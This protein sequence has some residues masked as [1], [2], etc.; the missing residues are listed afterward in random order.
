M[1]VKPGDEV[2]GTGITYGNSG[3]YFSA[4]WHPGNDEAEALVGKFAAP[5][6][7]GALPAWS[8]G[9]PG[10]GGFDAFL[11]ADVGADG[12]YFPGAS[13]SQ[14]SDSV[15]GKERKEIVAK[16]NLDGTSGSDT[17]G[18]VWV[19]RQRFYPGSNGYDGDEFFNAAR[20]SVEGGTTYFYGG[21]HAQE[22]GCNNNYAIRKYTATGATVWQWQQLSGA[23]G[24]SDINAIAVDGTNVYAAGSSSY[25][26]NVPQV[27][28]FSAAAGSSGPSATFTGT[29]DAGYTSAAYTSVA[30]LGGNIYAAGYLSNGERQAYLLDEWNT[31]GTRLVHQVWSSD[32]TKANSQQLTGITA[33]GSRL[34]V[35]GWTR[36]LDNPATA[37]NMGGP[38]TPVFLDNSAYHGFGDGV[39]FE[40]N[41]SNGDVVST[42]T[43]GTNDAK[44]QAF[45]GVTTDGTD[46]YV[47]GGERDATGFY[48]VIVQR[49][50]LSVPTTLTTSAAGSYGGTAT[51]QAAL[52]GSGGPISGATVNF[53]LSGNAVGS[54]VTGANGV[55]S[56]TNVSLAGVDAGS[57]SGVVGAAFAA[58]GNFQGSNATGDLTVSK[59]GATITVT[60]AGTFLYNGQT[61]AAA[62]SVTGVLVP[63][64]TLGSATITYTD[65]STNS[66]TS[67]APVNA[68]SYGVNASFAGNTNYLPGANN[69]LTI[70]ITP[71][72]TTTSAT[73][74]ANPS[75]FGQSVT[76]TATVSAVAPGAGTPTGTVTFKDA[77]TTLGTGTLIGGTTTFTTS[78]LSVASHTVTAV[79]GGDTNFTTST[80]PTVT[81]T[82]SQAST[83]TSVAS[84]ATPSVFGQPVTF[85]ATVAAVS[86]S[87]GTPSGT[88][89]FKD[90]ATTLG[91][92]TLSGGTA[93]FT[94]S[95]LSVASHVITASYSGDVSFSASAAQPVWQQLSPT[96]TGPDVNSQQFVS[97]GQGSLIMFGGCGPTG[98]N[99]SSNTFALRD[100]FGVNGTTAW[101][102]IPTTTNPGARHAHVLAYDS[103]LNELIASGGCAGGCYPLAPDTWKLTNGNGLG[104][105]TPTWSQVIPSAPPANG[106]LVGQFAAVDSAHSA[107][108]IYG[109]QN[110]GGSACSGSTTG[111]TETVNTSTFSWASLPTS[112]GPP[113]TQ[114][115]SKGGYDPNSN[116]LIISNG[117]GCAN[118]NELWILTHANGRDTGSTPT[119]TKL[120]SQGAAGS[121]PGGVWPTDYSPARNT[122]FLVEAS[123]TLVPNLWRLSNAN[124]LDASGTATTPAWTLATT[125]GGPSGQPSI[126]GIAYDSASD[127]LVAQLTVG[128][129]IQYWIIKSASGSGAS[130][131]QAVTPASTT[132]TVVSSANPSVS[133]QSVT[134]TATVSVTSPGAGTPTGAVTFKDGANTLGSGTV[135][136]SGQATFATSALSVAGHSITA[137]Y[138]GDTNFATSTS[139]ALSHTVNP[140]PPPTSVFTANSNPAACS[141][142]LTFDGSGSY[143]SSGLHVVSYAWNF[144]DGVTGTGSTTTHAYSTFGTY[145]ATLTVT[146]NNVPAKTGASTVVVNVNQGNHAPVANHGGPYSTD[147]GA[148][149]TLNGTGSS[150]ADTLCG[151][152]ITSYAW[153]IGAITFIAAS[154]SLTAAQVNALG[155][156]T[157]PVSL[158]VTD[159]FGV[160]N[161]A[162]TTLSI[163]NNVPT[164]SFTANPNPA[165]CQQTLTFNGSSSTAGRPDRAIVGYGWN[166]GDGVTASGSTT[167]HA[168]STFGSYNATLTVT[169]NNVPAK[170]GASTLV[171]NVNQGNSA[172]VANAG[173]PYTAS[174]GSAFALN[175]SG[176]S[177]PNASCGD[178][179]SYSWTIDGG[180]ITSTAQSPSLTVA[181]ISSLGVGNHNVSLTVTDIFGVNGNASTSLTIAD[182]LA[183]VSVTPSLPTIPQG[184]SQTFTAT[185]SYGSGAT[186]V[187]ANDSWTSGTPLTVASYGPGA[188]V[189]NG[190][191]YV[192]SG[193]V[194]QR[195]A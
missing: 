175:G 173:G 72:S 76:F 58:T 21:G 98:C 191:L 94:T 130:T 95:S 165:A 29:L 156:G 20:V 87:A 51:L 69:S 146:D 7:N 135:N 15:G 73:S 160:T 158:T 74:S 39:I 178:V 16:F 46:L 9:W 147:L 84:S 42:T 119:W 49:Y 154:P 166:F 83:T 142:S 64:D 176:S 184:G 8:R 187:L 186:R 117:W 192:I 114:Y 67:S 82:V 6:S 108:M 28:R 159:T 52:S 40:I 89:T 125:T 59:T 163:Y 183:S 93:T 150:D 44:D 127:R 168:Y 17:A 126:G 38:T 41:P 136:G 111:T 12:V 1:V 78:S 193:F 33:V 148:G 34:F 105:G 195:V 5:M 47:V 133:G 174:L 138:G 23:C 129:S 50:G 103:I 91:T 162:S 118:Y 13:Y 35:T 96:G 139:S 120:L 61:H 68:G 152:S 85:T 22:N 60:G 144:G 57:Y 177:D 97:D 131:S 171:V 56:L 37:H 62:G 80:S 188:A 115:L 18:A 24:G 182:S 32:A 65:L 90:G 116:R 137:V 100:A 26:G 81:Q 107:L 189:V 194:T 19:A 179:I 88:V 132:T 3:V 71:A 27:L 4:F 140:A 157:F 99:T 102:Q 54:T 2:V 169:D 31:S 92:G 77:S 185:A 66:T 112:G 113:G 149:V 63:T 109:G 172:P 143:A 134:F 104:V 181:Q 14:T 190:Q 121:P 75:V 86:P 55:A 106:Y 10:G 36:D 25:A 180:A 153:T 124:G 43:Y 164:A 101:V 30:L 48:H 170:T 167:T 11:G 141:Q 128:S 79:Y 123:S 161:T 70:T 110:G 45:T 53:T 122:L 155:V 151:D 145:S